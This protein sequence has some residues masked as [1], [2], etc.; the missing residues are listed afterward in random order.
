MGDCAGPPYSTLW[1][2]Q[3]PDLA[4]LLPMEVQ[5]YLHLEAKSSHQLRMNVSGSSTSGKG[6]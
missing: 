5:G 2:Y 6:G 3:Q 4:G 1:T